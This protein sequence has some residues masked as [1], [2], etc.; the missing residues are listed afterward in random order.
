MCLEA[1][2]LFGC[3]WPYCLFENN[4]AVDALGVLWLWILVLNLKLKRRSLSEF[5]KQGL[6]CQN[7][8]HSGQKPVQKPGLASW[9]YP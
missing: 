6:N 8:G 9:L 2:P 5:L 1:G 3:T 7:E 4:L